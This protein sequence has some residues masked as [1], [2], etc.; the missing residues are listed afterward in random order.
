MIR[1][2]S[3]PIVSTNLEDISVEDVWPTVW[4][5]AT[6]TKDQVMYYESGTSPMS[7]YFE[8]KDFDLTKKGEVKMLSLIDVKW[9]DRMGDV[10][11]KF[12]K[13]S[14]DECINTEC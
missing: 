4:R 10:A 5:V 6:D 14:K 13:A 9:Q 1:A 11:E 8:F 2:V 3:N 7:F 12:K